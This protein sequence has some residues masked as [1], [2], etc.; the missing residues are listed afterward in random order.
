MAASGRLR[1]ECLRQG[2]LQRLP[3]RRG[4]PRPL[5]PPGRHRQQPLARRH[6][7]AGGLPH[8][9][10]RRRDPPARRLSLALRAARPAQG[11]PQS[12]MSDFTAGPTSSAPG[13]SGCPID[14]NTPPV[15]AANAVRPYRSRR[16]TLPALPR[17]PKPRAHP[18]HRWGA[19]P[20]RR[21]I[22]RAPSFHALLHPPPRR[23]GFPMAVAHNR[24]LPRPPARPRSPRCTISHAPLRP[25]GGRKP[26]PG[27]RRI[28]SPTPSP[29][30]PQNAFPIAPPAAAPRPAA[31]GLVQRRISP[32]SRDASLPALRGAGE[33]LTVAALRL[34]APRAPT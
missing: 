22:I 7:Y 27:S 21:R 32:A 3:S 20:R 30:A 26:G 17:S 23:E 9:R 19:S 2:A 24:A 10:R 31:P 13:K 12:T 14:G 33:M 28:D 6:R 25:S 16:A 8:A 29:T 1:V 5:H 4:L 15:M 11:L 18:A 34:G